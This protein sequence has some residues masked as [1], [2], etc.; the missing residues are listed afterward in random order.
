M[1]DQRIPGEHQEAARRNRE[2]E[3]I[4]LI[5][6]V[7]WG[8]YCRRSASH[9]STS[10]TGFFWRKYLRPIPKVFLIDAYEVSCRARADKVAPR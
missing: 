4:L 8:N 3:W 6:D 9:R 5:E 1:D 10:G 7:V 2:I